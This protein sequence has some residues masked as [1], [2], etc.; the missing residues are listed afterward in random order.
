MRQLDSSITASRNLVFLPYGIGEN[1]LPQRR[2]S[3]RM[4]F[5]YALG[6]KK[7]PM[8]LVCDTAEAIDGF[9]YNFV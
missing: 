2:L 1:T 3:E 9:S 8:R 5:I 4:D 6:F 7:P